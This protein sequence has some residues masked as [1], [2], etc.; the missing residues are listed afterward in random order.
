METL[1]TESLLA[2]NFW[3]R[4]AGHSV[5]G[6]WFDF[7]SETI[8]LRR[9]LFSRTTCTCSL[10]PEH[11]LIDI[12]H[13]I[14]LKR[15]TFFINFLLFKSKLFK[16]QL[17]ISKLK[18]RPTKGSR[19]P[20]APSHLFR[21][22]PLLKSLLKLIRLSAGTSFYWVSDLKSASMPNFRLFHCNLLEFGS[23]HRTFGYF[24]IP[25]CP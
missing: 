5:W 1:Q 2:Q 9:V 16:S 25:F 18:M 8:P 7:F 12:S 10:R 17:W 21:S 11:S 20:K 15:Y 22:K 23:F 13:I 19:A 14:R 24:D 3:A 6:K 4:R